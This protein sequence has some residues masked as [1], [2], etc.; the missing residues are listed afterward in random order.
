MT[1]TT[2]IP[3]DV[4]T[5]HISFATLNQHR[6]RRHTDWLGD[7][8]RED[9]FLIVLGHR[10]DNRCKRGLTLQIVLLRDLAPQRI[11]VE[12]LLGF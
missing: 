12:V 5:T 4:P 11:Q 10:R 3:D 1:A 9:I 7:E 2:A 6:F 8:F